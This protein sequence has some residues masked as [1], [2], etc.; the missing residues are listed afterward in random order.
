MI[1]D[2]FVTGLDVVKTVDCNDDKNNE[3]DS[4]AEDDWSVEKIWFEV[5]DEVNVDFWVV[6]IFD[7]DGVDVLFTAGDWLVEKTNCDEIGSVFGTLVDKVLILEDVVKSDWLVG[8]TDEYN[9]GTEDKSIFDVEEET[10]FISGCKEVI[11]CIDWND[12]IEGTV[13]WETKG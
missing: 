4:V 10:L 5:K 6:W 1:R 9:W 7:E 12:V 2:G 8:L 3:Y 11:S 13:D